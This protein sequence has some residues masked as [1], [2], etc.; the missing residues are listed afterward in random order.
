MD[1]KNLTEVNT[2]HYTTLLKTFDPE[3][4]LIRLALEETNVNPTIVMRFIRALA[5]LDYGTGYGRVQT[6]MTKHIVTAIKY[7]ESDT[8]NLETTLKEEDKL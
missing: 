3:L 7:E 2:E 4:Y 5:N 1:D 6:F 8:L